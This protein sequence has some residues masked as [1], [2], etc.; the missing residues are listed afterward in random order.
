MESYLFEN[1]IVTGGA[2]FIGSNLVSYLQNLTKGSIFIIDSFGQSINDCSTHGSY[3]NLVGLKCIPLAG[4]IR[5]IKEIVSKSIKVPI[6][7]VFHMAAISDTTALDEN[8]VIDVNFNSFFDFL[9]ICD[10]FSAPIVYASSGAVYGN[11]ICQTNNLGSESPNNVYGY[12][13]YSMD[14][15]SKELNF[16]TKK[17]NKISGLRFFNVY[18]PNENSKGKSSSMIIQL[19]NQ[20]LENKSCKLFEN[21][22]KIYRDFIYVED[23]CKSIVSAIYQDPGIYNAGTGKCRSFLEVAEIII[24]YLKIEEEAKIQ[25][26]PNPYLDRY[27]FKTL[28]P[29][30]ETNILNISKLK[31][32]TLE[33]GINKY[34]NKINE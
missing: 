23:I 8:T 29:W 21:S 13:K 33:E 11:K 26:I 14:S 18:G 20:F 24:K 34:L 22:E 4:D 10:H 32:L 3:K 17:G 5:N 1:V 6:S 9:E 16:R 25:Y 30:D 31:P 2:G 19:Y 28:A 12:S 7:A 27:Q 15:V